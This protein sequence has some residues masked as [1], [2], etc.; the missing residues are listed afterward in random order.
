MVQLSATTPQH[1]QTA[2][3]FLAS[4]VS[5]QDKLQGPSAR[6]PYLALL[7]LL[8]QLKKAKRELEWEQVLG[9]GM[10]IYTHVCM[11]YSPW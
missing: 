3:L 7:E 10:S 6:A 8:R 11:Y 5:E 2:K 9:L 4:L 1:L